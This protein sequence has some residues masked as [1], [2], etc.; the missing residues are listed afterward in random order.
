MIKDKKVEKLENS[1][2]KLTVTVDQDA[3]AKEYKDLVSGYAKNAQI[4]GFRKGKVP[5][6]VLERKFGDSFRFETMQKVLEESL[7]TVFD[8]IDEKP[9][10][11]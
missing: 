11:Y 1:A 7:R 6:E 8:E 5:T 10:P 4:K 9:L 2:V 3:V